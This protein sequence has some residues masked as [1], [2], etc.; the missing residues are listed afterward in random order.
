MI[1]AGIVMTFLG[2]LIAVGSLGVTASVGGRMIMVLI[3]LAVSLAGII[4]VL[5]R[6]YLSKAIWRK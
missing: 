6:A 2:F 5:N 1:V 3:G 4:G